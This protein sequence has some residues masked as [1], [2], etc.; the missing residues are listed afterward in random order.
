MQGLLW[1][2]SSSVTCKHL[3]MWEVLQQWE[4]LFRVYNSSRVQTF[5]FEDTLGSSEFNHGCLWGQ[6]PSPTLVWG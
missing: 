3:L 1:E 5:A 6:H 4:T 2:H